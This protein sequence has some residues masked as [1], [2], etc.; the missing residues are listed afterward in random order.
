[1]KPALNHKSSRRF[2]PISRTATLLLLAL[3][4]GGL[5]WTA[6]ASLRQ[7]RLNRALI[8]AI[9]HLTNQNEWRQ[10][11][12]N[13]ERSRYLP[14]KVMPPLHV[15]WRCSIPNDSAPSIA[16]GYTIYLVGDQ[17]SLAVRTGDGR[18]LWT[19]PS[20]L[21]LDMSHAVATA[22]AIIAW[23]SMSDKVLS[24]RPRDRK[25]LFTISLRTF[26][27]TGLYAWS[28]VFLVKNGHLI[29]TDPGEGEPES[30]H[31]IDVNLASGRIV[32][33]R[34]DH[35]FP[36]T[37]WVYG[38]TPNFIG[39][40]PGPGDWLFLRGGETI[41]TIEGGIKG[42][43][44]GLYWGIPSTEIAAGRNRIYFVDY[45]FVKALDRRARLIWK[46]SISHPRSGHMF[47]PALVLGPDRLIVSDQRYL[48]GLAT[49]S[50]HILWRSDRRT[51]QGEREAVAPLAIGNDIY[52]LI[53]SKQ[54]GLVDSIAALSLRT[55]C[56][57][58]SMKVGH[59]LGPMIAHRGSLYVFNT[60]K[61]PSY[62][63]SGHRIS[64][65]YE[66]IKLGG[67]R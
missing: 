41:L 9:K 65:N 40:I 8:P 31:L 34:A 63:S 38:F 50:G 56:K 24:F 48:Y 46:T 33:V 1:M 57:I 13:A 11:D 4:V 26:D 47:L 10:K 7:E 53:G 55:G 66:L 49:A 60:I 18:I 54:G 29:V 36:T 3:L 28:P 32:A 51:G 19:L 37:R 23:D 43:V 59:S 5:G 42:Q 35:I 39:E 52:V 2:Q 62:S 14:D 30:F 64:G 67:R 44:H 21:K 16:G 22:N 61:E 25:P 45:P 6:C 58:W 20:N 27:R 15:I 17:L 12:A